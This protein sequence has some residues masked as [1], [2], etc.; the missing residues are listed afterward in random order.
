MNKHHLELYHNI[1]LTIEQTLESHILEQ[2]Q[3]WAI[4]HI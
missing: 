3:S 1:W 2:S 4:L